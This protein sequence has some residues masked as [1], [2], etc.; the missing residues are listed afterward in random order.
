LR[1]KV[2]VWYEDD[3][4]REMNRKAGTELNITD[5]LPVGPAAYHLQY[6]YIV[7]NP[8]PK[9]R[10][11][12]VD[13]PGDGSAYTRQHT[14]YHP[15]M[16]GAA[17]G[18]G[19]FDL[20][21]ADP[22]SGRLFYTVAKEVDFAMS[23]RTGNLRQSSVAAAVARCAVSTDRSAVCFEDFA[24][25]APSRGAPTAFMAAP[26]IDQGVVVAVLVAQLSIQEIDDVVTG[27]RHWRQDGF[28]ATGEAYVVGSDGL[29]RSGP[30]AF[31]ETPERYYVELKHGGESDEDIAAIRRYG[32]PVLHQHVTTEA[33]RA[34]LAGI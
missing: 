33:A 7:T 2:G 26:V 10:R 16:R 25:Y 8:H 18:F 5:Y 4:L 28:G 3:F 13:D 31:Y 34:G 24:P 32:T 11:S 27:D 17:T 20:M 9:D 30:R 1:R 22:R 12:L 6:H 23:L 15:L 19:F 29:A 14:V 21:L